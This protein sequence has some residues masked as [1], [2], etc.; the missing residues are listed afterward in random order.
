[1]M[2]IFVILKRIV[3]QMNT[4]SPNK[5]ITVKVTPLCFLKICSCLTVTKTHITCTN[6]LALRCYQILSLDVYYGSPGL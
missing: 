2:F 1:M 3:F 5:G 6:K 4:F